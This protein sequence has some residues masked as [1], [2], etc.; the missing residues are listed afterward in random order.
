MKGTAAL[1]IVGAIV[2]VGCGSNSLPPETDAARGREILKTVL[3]GWAGGKSMDDMKNGS[4]P[5]IAR[6]P[7]WKAGYKL[8]SYEIDSKDERSGV[9]LAVPVKLMISKGG[10]PPQERKVKFNIG[11]GSQTVCMR[12]E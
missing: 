9:D 1:A 7:D 12:Q 5:I 11:I 3:D 10:G 6:D 2:L 4:P 8:V